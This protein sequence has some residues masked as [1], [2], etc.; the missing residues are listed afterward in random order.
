MPAPPVPFVLALFVA[1]VPALPGCAEPDVASARPA[2]ASVSTT[3]GPS[4][5]SPADTLVAEPDA[6]TA[7][8][9]ASIHEKAAADGWASLPYGALVQRVG[10]ALIGQPYADGLLDEP[11]EETLVVTLRAFDCVL[12]IENVLA[13]AEGIATGDASYEGYVGRVARMRYRDGEMG[14]YCSRLHYF[15]EWIHDNEARGMLRNVTLEAG[16]ER[17]DKQINFMSGHRDA[18]P[19]LETDDETYACI[20]DMEAGL[21]DVKL[22]YIPQDRIAEAYAML[23]PGDIIAT[24]TDIGGL[25]VTH[26]GFVHKTDARTGFMHASLTSKQVTVSNDLESYVQGVRSQIGVV[27]ARPLD[28]REASVGG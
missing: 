28:P 20:V 16:G 7:R 11:E 22:F 2:V 19:K 21:A 6:E 23:Q 24:A 25:D 4:D 5:L 9:F 27:V 18:Y 8:L 10:E 1:L 13:L 15:S 14:S 17:F 12:Y 26:T 3:V